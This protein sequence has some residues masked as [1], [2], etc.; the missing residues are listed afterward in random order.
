VQLKAEVQLINDVEQAINSVNL[1]GTRP[2]GSLVSLQAKTE[3][4]QLLLQ[5]EKSRLIVWLFPLDYHRHHSYSSSSAPT[6]A[7][8]LT[9]AKTAWSESPALTV[10][11]AN[12]FQSEKLTS[13]VRW[14]ILNFPEKFV[15]E[16]DALEILLGLELPNDVSY[17]LKVRT[18]TY[19]V[20]QLLTSS[21]LALLGST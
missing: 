1:I 21:V 10:Q 18:G 4:L 2:V 6:E 3:L 15:N 14:R 17:H 7:A 5:S 19:Y 16:P 12:R 8:L 20:A 11:L 9:A 13:D